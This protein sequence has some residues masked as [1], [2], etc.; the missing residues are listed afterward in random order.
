M[1]IRSSVFSYNENNNM[2]EL[3]VKSECICHLFLT[4]KTTVTF[5]IFIL[6]G[7]H[8]ISWAVYFNLMDIVT[9]LL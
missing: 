4:I 5:N 2:S 7:V 8:I 3:F 9:H 1:F 6:V